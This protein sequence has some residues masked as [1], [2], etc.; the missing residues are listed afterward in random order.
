MTA[1][2]DG[3]GES[4]RLDESERQRL[5]RIGRQR[6][7]ALKN[8]LAEAGFVFSIVMSQILTEYFISGFTVLVPTVIKDLDIAPESATWPASAFS[9]VIASTLLPFGR[10]AD[11]YGGFV[12]YMFGLSWLTAWALIVGFAQNE[13]MLD[14]CRAI[15]GIGS[16]AFLPAGLMLLGRM[17]RPG[18]RKNI[19]FSI[20]GAMAALGFFIGLLGAG[21]AGQYIGWRWYFFIGAILSALTTVVAYFTIPSDWTEYKA[22]ESRMDWLGTVTICA[23]LVLFVF[24][25]TDSSGADNGWKSPYIIV[26]LILSVVLFAAAFYIEGWVA[27]Q[28][29]LPFDVFKIKYVLY[30][31]G[32]RADRQIRAPVYPRAVLCIRHAGHLHSLRDAL[33]SFLLLLTIAADVKHPQHYGRA[34]LPAGSMVHTPQHRR[35]LHRRHRRHVAARRVR[36]RHPLHHG[37]CHHHRLVALRHHTGGR[38]LLALGLPCHV[39][40]N[41]CH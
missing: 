11:I 39:L 10:L 28:P 40:L 32:R 5:E 25:V 8:A 6:P 26:T 16:A 29:L 21:V 23:G 35:V 13:I 7:P 24:A 2:K 12:V 34:A 19:I 22:S 41:H 27:E 14:V 31:A 9:L 20:Y 30:Y 4:A 18:P 1:S 36:Q 33:V 3:A 37:R 17:Y 38:R 15:Q